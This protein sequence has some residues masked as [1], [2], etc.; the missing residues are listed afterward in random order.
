M[1][2]VQL[3][4]A[5]S[6]N[7]TIVVCCVNYSMFAFVCVLGCGS[8]NSLSLYTT[9]DDNRWVLNASLFTCY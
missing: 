8:I 3:D 1:L 4:Q 7:D 9:R 5:V 2:A 6:H